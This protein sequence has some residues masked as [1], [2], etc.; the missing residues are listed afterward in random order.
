VWL[1]EQEEWCQDPE[2][3]I[4]IVS[5]ETITA[6]NLWTINKRKWVQDNM[7]H[8]VFKSLNTIMGVTDPLVAFF[9]SFFFTKLYQDGHG[10][11]NQMD[12][13]CYSGVAS[14]NKKILRGIPI[15]QMN[16]LVFLF[17]EGKTHWICFVIFI[18]LK[19][20]RHSIP[21]DT[22]V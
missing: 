19:I 1:Q 7:L 11:P 3:T 22:V 14:W 17:N 5:G 21:L 10:D 8:H 2:E 18:D 6:Q 16:M 15:D 9:P 4:A 13:Y 12:I 20:F